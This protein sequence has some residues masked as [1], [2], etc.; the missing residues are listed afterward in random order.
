[1]KFNKAKCKILHLGQ[2]NH[3]YQHRLEDEIESSSKLLNYLLQLL[4]WILENSG[5]KEK[6]GGGGAGGTPQ[7]IENL[8]SKKVQ[9]TERKN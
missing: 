3:Q 5:T 6:L 2:H 9:K 7:N 8:R 1:M 4:L